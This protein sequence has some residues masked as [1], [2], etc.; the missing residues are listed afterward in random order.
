MPKTSDYCPRCQSVQVGLRRADG[1]F[2]C[3]NCSTKQEVAEAASVPVR[4]HRGEDLR[5]SKSLGTTALVLGLLSALGAV[6]ITLY[7]DSAGDASTALLAIIPASLIPLG[8]G[9]L[10]GRNRRGQAGA[11]LS[12]L[13]CVQALFTVLFL[14]S[15][16]AVREVAGTGSRPNAALSTSNA[17]RNGRERT[18]VIRTPSREEIPVV[19]DLVPHETKPEQRFVDDPEEQARLA[20]LEALQ[21]KAANERQ[22]LLGLQRLKEMTGKY[23]AKAEEV[24]LLESQVELLD[25]KRVRLKGQIQTCELR[26]RSAEAKAEIERQRQPHNKQDLRTAIYGARRNENPFVE[27]NHLAL[28]LHRHNVEMQQVDAELDQLVPMLAGARAQATVLGKALVEHCQR[29][30]EPLPEVRDFMASDKEPRKAE[31]PQP[32]KE[33][34]ASPEKTESVSKAP[35]EKGPNVKVYVLHDGRT[36]KAQHVIEMGKELA[37]RDVDGDIHQIKKADVREIRE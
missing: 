29:I 20:S 36:I 31:D 6:P 14:E 9:L 2:L 7:F 33:V 24:D 25:A 34:Q 13:A 35:A 28:E 18:P 8:A 12:L 16:G 37:I 4:V 23:Y 11:V 3:L 15:R 1:K 30:G 27:T 17:E 19:T 26:M 21:R 10:A 5:S 22:R 32:V